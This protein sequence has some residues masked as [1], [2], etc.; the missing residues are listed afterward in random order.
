MKS[1]DSLNETSVG[2][3]SKDIKKIYELF[4]LYY[5]LKTYTDENHAL[6][7]NKIT[8]RLNE[9]TANMLTLQENLDTEYFSERTISRK[10]IQLSC[11]SEDASVTQSTASDLLCSIIMGG[12]VK[13]KYA[14]GVEKKGY[15]LKKDN[16]KRQ[17]RFYFEPSL[18]SGDMNLIIGSILSN[19]FLTQTEKEY[20]TKRL[21][22]IQMFDPKNTSRF[23]VLPERP[24]PEK[25]K[26][27]AFLPVD[28]NRFLEHIQILNDA[29]AR[30]IK[31]DV[32]YG[33]YDIGDKNGRGN[34]TFHSRSDTAQTLNPY[35][36]MWNNGRYYLIAS[37]DNYENPT[38]YRVDR[39]ISVTIHTIQNDKGELICPKRNKIPDSLKDF[40]TFVGKKTLVFDSI[41][42]ANRY[43]SMRINHATNL[44]NCTIE[45]TPWSLQILV[46][47]FGTNLK[48]EPSPIMHDSKETDYNGKPQQFLAVTVFNVQY[49]NMRDF[50]LSHPQ[51]LT[52]I[53]PGKLVTEVKSILE[54][55]TKRLNQIKSD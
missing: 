29:I 41:A 39:M 30:Q 16:S 33:I 51:Y 28:S 25:K 55:S 42:Y 3:I 23:P 53:S 21:Q 46:D 10:L 13:T 27:Q 48:I 37:N 40:F 34:L 44:V 4:L 31:V 38:H 15:S 26:L 50:C 9:I 24:K 12:I 22:L 20:L 19:R 6:S 14:A 17:T 54:A 32:I 5:V 2:T 47:T 35:A 52:V 7:A 11:L 49:D 18:T 45:C 1:N 36:L 8:E 43:P